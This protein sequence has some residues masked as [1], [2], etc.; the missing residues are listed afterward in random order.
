MTLRSIATR[1]NEPS[2]K[3]TDRLVL[4]VRRGFVQVGEAVVR[5]CD[6]QTSSASRLSEDDSA[7]NCRSEGFGVEGRGPGEGP[8]R[9]PGRPSVTEDD[10]HVGIHQARSKLI[11]QGGVD[12]DSGHVLRR[13]AQNFG[14]K[15]G[16]G[17][18]STTRGPRSTRSMAPGR[19]SFSRISCQSALVQNSMWPLF[20]SPPST[21]GPSLDLPAGA[22]SADLSSPLPVTMR[23]ES[24][25]R[26][27]PRRTIFTGNSVPLCS[28]RRDNSPSPFV[29]ASDWGSFVRPAPAAPPSRAPAP[30]GLDLRAARCPAAPPRGVSSRSREDPFHYP[31]MS[32]GAKGLEPVVFCRAPR[33][34]FGATADKTMSSATA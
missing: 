24:G 2:T 30:V 4:T 13:T 23:S 31:R 10:L 21:C 8:G 16:P 26:I 11:D 28:C 25:V 6:D 34:K 15:P 33:S 29:P 22:G 17:P 14:G 5:K 9:Q 32:V 12:L 18:I 7:F 27:S 1:R 19:I 3:H 20:I